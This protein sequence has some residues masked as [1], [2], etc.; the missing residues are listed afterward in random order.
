M[1]DQVTFAYTN[2]LKN[3]RK[4]KPTYCYLGR[5]QRS[6]LEEQA[7]RNAIEQKTTTDKLRPTTYFG[8]RIVWVNKLNHIDFS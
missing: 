7:R 3:S 8:A 2:F 5:L 4:D 1:I 6:E